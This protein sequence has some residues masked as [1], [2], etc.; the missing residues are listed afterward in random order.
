[1]NIMTS[2]SSLV[3][4]GGMALSASALAQASVQYKVLQLRGWEL[5]EQLNA[6]A[7]AGWRLLEMTTRTNCR[8]VTA[9]QQE[10]IEPECFMVVL[11]MN[12]SASKGGGTPSK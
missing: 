6:N 2:L 12:A 3:F 1:M 8:F 10:K 11:E 5:E 7:H 4:A 9:L